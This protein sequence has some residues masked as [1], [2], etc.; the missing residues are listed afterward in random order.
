MLDNKQP[1][2]DWEWVENVPFCEGFSLSV[3]IPSGSFPAL[4]TF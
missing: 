4:G 1:L 3:E 2:W